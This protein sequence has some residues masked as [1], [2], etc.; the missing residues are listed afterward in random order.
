MISLEPY[1]L[2]PI[3]K[4][5]L[6][7]LISGL[8]IRYAIPVIVRIAKAKKIYDM[9]NGRTAHQ[10]P[11]PRLGGVGIYLSVLLISL[12]LIDINKFPQ[13]QYILAGSTIIFFIGLKDDILSVA[14]W[15]KL[16]GQL[17]ATSFIVFFADIRLTSLHGFFGLNEI[18]Y[19]Q[20]IL[21][22]FFVIILIINA[23]NLID[24]V[25]G[26]SG[27]LAIISF[28][29]LGVWFY[30]NKSYEITIICVS[31]T[32]SLGAFLLFN[33]WAKR[34]KVFLGDTGALFIGYLLAI[35]IIVFCEMNTTTNVVMPIRSAPIV[36]FCILIIPLLDTARIFLIR[37][38][39]GRSPFSADK[40]HIH[41]Y[42]LDLGLNHLQITAILV[43]A[44]IFF[45]ILAY[46]L[47]NLNIYLLTGIIVLTA[48]TLSSIPVFIYEKR[49][50]NLPWQILKPK[51]KNAA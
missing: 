33:I 38:L 32:G 48:L 29:A 8:F 17:I 21:I 30:L 15:K 9:P 26:L 43:A 39:Q 13:F 18:S 7:F 41:H 10:T 22:S 46:L 36:A 1:L 23:F 14:S 6:A 27:S 2:N 31:M 45:I 40:N 49:A 42:L 3:A 37:I 24:G 35:F 11:T 25:D 47:Q 28:F 20:S 4:I 50:R 44:N 16:G 5:L 51:K 12:L 34:R 19:F